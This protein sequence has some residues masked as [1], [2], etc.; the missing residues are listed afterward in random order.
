MPAQRNAKH[1]GD[2]KKR[3]YANYQYR[4]PSNKAKRLARHKLRLI[5][6]ESKHLRILKGSARRLRRSDMHSFNAQRKRRKQMSGV[7]KVNAPSLEMLGKYIG[8][9]E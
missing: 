5:R 8:K 6:Q 4:G 3:Y 7:I 9:A 1:T 2:S